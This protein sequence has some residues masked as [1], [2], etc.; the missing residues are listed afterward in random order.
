MT[1]RE[2]WVAVGASLAG[3]LPARVA[4]RM[5]A[6]GGYD[7]AV[8]L[9]AQAFMSLLPMLLVLAAV[10]PSWMSGSARGTVIAALGLSGSAA[11]ALTD[12]LAQPVGPRAG[13]AEPLTAISAVLGFTRSLQRTHLAA[14][15]LPSRG[16]RGW[17]HGLGAAAS[18]VAELALVALLGAVL[19]GVGLP[20]AL[21][22]HA[23]AGTL[24]WWP[25]QRLLVGGRIGW[26]ALLPG[27]AVTG[28]GQAVVVAV[29]GLYL[30]VAVAHE[31]ARY[32]AVGVAVAFVSWLVVLGV[33][34]VVAAVLGAELARGRAGPGG[35]RV[36][37]R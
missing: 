26:R 13:G 5:V 1:T 15:D 37:A 21:L 36:T 31:A 4:R 14:W 30:P 9:A 2:R 28:V 35:T 23:L 25:V 27:A 8:A 19:G 24:L 11:Q 17:G 20:F 10:L 32:G 33:L 6:I 29:S 22:G 7:R 34:L 18:V 12:V 16:L 3:T